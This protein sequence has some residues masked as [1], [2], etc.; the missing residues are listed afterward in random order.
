[1]IYIIFQY[2]ISS[3]NFLNLKF[4]QANITLF[5]IFI[6]EISITRFKLITD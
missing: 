1:M 2:I 6:K 3:K 4:I 5:L